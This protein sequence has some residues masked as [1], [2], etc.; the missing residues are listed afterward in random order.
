MSCNQSPENVSVDHKE[1]VTLIIKTT[2]ERSNKR[3]IDRTR[4]NHMFTY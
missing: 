4:R 1:E 2:H 3:E